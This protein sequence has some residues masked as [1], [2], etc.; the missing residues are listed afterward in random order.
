MGTDEG[1]PQII[2]MRFQTAL[3]SDMWPIFVELHLASSD[4]RGQEKKKNPW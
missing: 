1:I 4:I 3:C 2:D